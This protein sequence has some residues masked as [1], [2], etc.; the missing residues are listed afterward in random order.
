MPFF[1]GTEVDRA[2]WQSFHDGLHLIEG[3]TIGTG[4]IPVAEGAGEVALVGKAEAE[5][6]HCIRRFGTR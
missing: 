6:N 1:A 3:E 2:D 5:R 4:R